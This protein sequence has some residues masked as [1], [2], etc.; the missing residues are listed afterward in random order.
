[1]S[2]NLE[3]LQHRLEHLPNQDLF[4]FRG[5]TDS[6]DLIPCVVR[7]D[8]QTGFCHVENEVT[9]VWCWHLL[10]AWYQYV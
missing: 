4:R 7:A 10:R 8:K 2:S 5:V 3:F 1:M 6:G 9:G